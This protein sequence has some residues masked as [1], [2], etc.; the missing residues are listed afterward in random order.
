MYISGGTEQTLRCSPGPDAEEVEGSVHGL[1]LGEGGIV[2]VG[3]RIGGG[4]V[5][6]SSLLF[7]GAGERGGAGGGWSSCVI[8]CLRPGISQ[9][10]RLNLVSHDGLWGVRPQGL[11]AC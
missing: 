11:I 9:H 4:G 1:V 5:F 3:G 10:P 8:S 2:L 7:G 6:L